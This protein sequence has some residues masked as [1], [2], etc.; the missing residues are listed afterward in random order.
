LRFGKDELYKVVEILDD[1]R[2]KLDTGLV[3]KLRGIVISDLNTALSYLREYV[4]RKKVYL[5]FDDGYTPK[6][7][8]VEAYVYLKNGIFINAYLIKSGLAKVDRSSEFGLKGKFTTLER[9][10]LARRES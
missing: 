10:K 4:L 7:N 5:K 8:H 2:L 1:G 9:S 6:G 3:V